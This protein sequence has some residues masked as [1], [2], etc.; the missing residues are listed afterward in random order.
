MCNLADGGLDVLAVVMAWWITFTV[1]IV[2]A[3]SAG[4]GPSGI[5]AGKA[6]GWLAVFAGADVFL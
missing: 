6:A 2:I 4:F 5:I 3:L 1:V